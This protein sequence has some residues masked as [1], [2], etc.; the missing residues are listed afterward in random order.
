MVICFKF[1]K[2]V[3]RGDGEI[4]VGVVEWAVPCTLP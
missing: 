1:R 4:V 3:E 2:A